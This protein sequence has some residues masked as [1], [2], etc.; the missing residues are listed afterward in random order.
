MLFDRNLVV[1]I[2]SSTAG[3]SSALQKWCCP[4]VERQAS[5]FAAS[6]ASAEAELTALADN[7]DDDTPLVF[8][9]P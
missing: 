6:A 3:P 2:P 7:L 4:N 8:M 1:D 9:R 5:R